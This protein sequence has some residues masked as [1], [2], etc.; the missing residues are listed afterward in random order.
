MRTPRKLKRRRIGAKKLDVS[1]L[2]R[3]IRDQRAWVKL[4]IV[5]DVDDDGSHFALVEDE[6]GNV[7]DV[8]VEVETVPDRVQLTC[9]LTGLVGGAGAG[10]W[11]VPAID[12][13]VLV[14][15]PDGELDFMACI[16][17]TLGS[18]DVPSPDAA[19]EPSP[20]R[21][22]I[23]NGEV[24]IHD[25]TGGTEPLVK[26][27]EFD[28]HEHDYTWTDPG[29]S[30]TTDRPNNSPITGTTILKAL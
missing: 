3:A 2:K 26:K 28:A 10:I 23:V 16:V 22:L 13:E 29:G 17:A 6:A 1:D 9:R 7:V 30:G 18:R 15:L 20:G 11:A 5:V 27:S 21:T 14:C 25:G 4:A 19:H 24:L 8:V 12:D